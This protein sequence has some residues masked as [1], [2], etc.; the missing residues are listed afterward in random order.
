[1][2]GI[3]NENYEIPRKMTPG[4]VVRKLYMKFNWNRIMGNVLHRVPK[5]DERERIF[6]KYKLTEKKV[7]FWDKFFFYRIFQK[8]SWGMT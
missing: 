6:S 2:F 5:F 1:M 4:I 8:K 7:F 3:K